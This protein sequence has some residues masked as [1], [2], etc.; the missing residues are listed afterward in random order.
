METYD[1]G[2]PLHWVARNILTSDEIPGNIINGLLLARQCGT[3]RVKQLMIKGLLSREVSFYDSI[4]RS[5][6]VTALKEKTKE[7]E[8]S[9]ICR[10]RRPQSS[11]FIF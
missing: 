10:Q 9:N 2:D 8:K 1:Y 6:I 11:W 4:Q 5:T 7:T 3:E